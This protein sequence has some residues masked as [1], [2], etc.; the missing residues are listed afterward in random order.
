M[1]P[2]TFTNYAAETDKR[3]QELAMKM[4][5]GI[6]AV[7]DLEIAAENLGPHEYLF[8][9]PGGDPE[10]IREAILCVAADLLIASFSNKPT[11]RDASWDKFFR[12]A[13][14]DLAVRVGVDPAAGLDPVAVE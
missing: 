1:T 14:S 4:L 13:V 3:A 10:V 5:H 7:L 2:H 8:S 11:G 9:Q 12:K 6:A